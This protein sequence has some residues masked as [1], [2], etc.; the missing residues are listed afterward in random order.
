MA[1]VPLPTQLGPQTLS[2]N[3]VVDPFGVKKRPLNQP[4]G[5]PLSGKSTPVRLSSPLPVPNSPTPSNSGSGSGNAGLFSE[6]G[7]YEDWLK[8]HGNAFDNPSNAENFYNSGDGASRLGDVSGGAYADWYAA[9]P[10]AF[11]AP[12]QRESMSGELTGDLLGID[13]SGFSYAPPGSSFSYS[14]PSIGAG[15]EAYARGAAGMSDPGALEALYG[16]G[17]ADALGNAGNMEAFYSMYGQDPMQK[18]YTENLYEQGMGRLNPYYDYA[19]NRAVA[20]AQR[21]SAARGGFNSGLAAQQESD[22]LGNL[23]GQQA[24]EQSDLAPLADQERTARYRLGSDLANTTDQET[25]DRINALFGIAKDTQGAEE[26]RYKT[27]GDLA[28]ISDTGTEAE[29]RLGLDTEKARSDAEAAAARLGLD[30][31]TARTN[32]EDAANRTRISAINSAEDVAAGAD[33]SARNR[34]RDQEEAAQNASDLDLRQAAENR[35][36]VADIYGEAQGADTAYNAR[37]AGAA[38]LE[39]DLQKTGQDRI[40]SMINNIAGQDSREANLLTNIYSDMS[41]VD[42]VDEAWLQA[43]AEKLGIPLEQ[44][45]DYASA[46]GKIA[47]LGISAAK[48][49]NG[50]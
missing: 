25:R 3:P 46:L 36:R 26:D 42:K 19:S 37:V 6:P 9:H 47:D 1:I 39:S 41:S 18:G 14:G 2:T 45:K 34:T 33:E 23:R 22:I 10:D 16:G 7:A 49:S 32:A 44:M 4:L 15:R 30:T 29:G 35:Q 50:K 43:E 27:L 8:A 28:R 38:G 17:G 20:D 31:E 40:Q 24:K 48:A 5:A 12:G 11:N 13:S 21:S